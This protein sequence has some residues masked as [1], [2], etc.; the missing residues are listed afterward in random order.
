MHKIPTL[1]LQYSSRNKLL[2]RKG[3]NYNQFLLSKIWVDTKK[4]IKQFP[5]FLT[6]N[7]CKS[8]YN[9]VIHHMSYKYIFDYNMNK[10]KNDLICLCNLCHDNVHKLANEK[11]LGLRH[12]VR[13][14]TKLY[15]LKHS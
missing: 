7:I 5:E 4:Y 8:E 10:R 13:K 9:L 15:K 11:L 1:I 14:Y 2:A 6:C 12:A 3:M